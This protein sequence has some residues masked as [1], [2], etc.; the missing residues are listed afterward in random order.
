MNDFFI[1]DIDNN[2]IPN[3]DGSA[4]IIHLAKELGKCNLPAEEAAKIAAAKL[5]ERQSHNSG[6]YRIQATRGLTGGHRLVPRVKES[7]K[8]VKYLITLRFDG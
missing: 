4:D 2:G 3:S 5:S 8:E 6:W 1:V 7:F